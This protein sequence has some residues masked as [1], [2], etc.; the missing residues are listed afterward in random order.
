MWIRD[1]DDGLYGYHN[2]FINEDMVSRYPALICHIVNM[3][4]SVR[5]F[6]SSFDMGT[7]ERQSSA[8][9]YSSHTMQAPLGALSV[10]LYCITW[11]TTTAVG[12][13]Y[14]IYQAL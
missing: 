1:D 3:D 11:I 2:V 4:I 9:T 10:S 14:C 13:I 5:L 8:I 7:D 6:P 12:V